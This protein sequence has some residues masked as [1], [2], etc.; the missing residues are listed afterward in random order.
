MVLLLLGTTLVQKVTSVK[1]SFGQY[2][3][4]VTYPSFFAAVILFF[5]PSYAFTDI[6]IH[7]ASGSNAKQAESVILEKGLISD[8]IKK[9]YNEMQGAGKLSKFIRPN[10]EV[11]VINPRSIWAKPELNLELTYSYELIDPI[12]SDSVSYY[13]RGG[14]ELSSNSVVLAIAKSFEISVKRYLYKYFQLDQ[15][16][17]IAI[18]GSADA[19]PIRRK[20]PYKGEFDYFLKDTKPVKYICDNSFYEFDMGA[21]DFND[22]CVLALL[23]ALSIRDFINNEIP[24]LHERADVIY[25]Y[26]GVH[27]KVNKGGQYRKA[28]IKLTLYNVRLTNKEE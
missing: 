19:Y 26:G 1:E 13:E 15:K 10:F 25:D 11:R 8:Q 5:T 21:Q 23:R 27:D 12:Y 3:Y 2:L 7:L 14:Y 6:N 17:K 28:E 24:M 9:M 20:I 18:V 22:N 4:H 16:V